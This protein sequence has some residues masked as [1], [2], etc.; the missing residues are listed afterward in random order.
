M[1]TILVGGFL[2]HCLISGAFFSPAATGGASLPLR[3]RKDLLWIKSKCGI[4][5]DG[6]HSGRT[7]HHHNG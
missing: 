4:G 6:R 3:N 2:S 1:V 7:D 5:N